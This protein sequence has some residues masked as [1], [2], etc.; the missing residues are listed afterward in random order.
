MRLG[1]NGPNG[2]GKSLLTRQL[3]A[4]FNYELIK[5]PIEKNE[6][7]NFFYENKDLF[8]YLGQNA[9]YAAMFTLMWNHKDQK[10]VIFDSTFYSNIIYTKLLHLAGYMNEHQY[11][12]SLDIAKQHIRH[13]PKLDLEIIIKRPK[14]VLFQNVHH[15]NRE[16]EQGQDNYLNFHFDNYYPVAQAVYREFGIP[17]KNILMIEVG[18]LKDL[19]EIQRIARL[20]ETR[21]NQ[22]KEN[23]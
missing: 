10:N 18:D 9:F 13:L 6:Y 23:E 15:R 17:Q 1:I 21:Y 2:A 22:G 14:D 8:S 4:F 5:E 20:I 19:N 11:Q 12:L 3:A 7:L 16:M